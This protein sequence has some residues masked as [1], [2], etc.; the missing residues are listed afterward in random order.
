MD[1]HMNHEMSMAEAMESFTLN[2]VKDG[3]ILEGKILKVNPDEVI[4]NINYFADGVVPREELTKDH[5][6]SLS[7]LYHVGDTIKVIVLRA[8]DGEGNVLLSKIQADAIVSVEE[9]ESAFRDKTPLK[10]KIMDE[11]KGG[12]R[13]FY[14]GLSG[15]MPASLVSDSYVENLKEFEGKTVDALVEEFDDVQKKLIFS[16][17][18]YLRLMGEKNKKKLLQTL[19]PGDT[20]EGTVANLASYGAFIDLGGLTGLCHISDLSHRRVNHPSEVLSIGD[21]VTVHVLKV[22]LKNEKISLSLKNKEEDP[23]TIAGSLKIGQYYEG[24]VRRLLDIGAIVELDNGLD[25]LVHIS[26]ISHEH[27]SHPKDVLQEGQTVRVKVLEID[28]DKKRISFSLRDGSGEDESYYEDEESV[29]LGD[30]FK[31][32]LD[33]LKEDE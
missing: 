23:W 3:D 28:E 6:E 21:T 20:V 26:E 16:R 8:D 14:N 24:T 25:G 10:V 9:V 27:I 31:N 5:N 12:L 30:L 2:K 29:T 11:V 32:L 33:Q 1:E 4:V 18:A 17:K 7:D 22:D 19:K 15:F 13:I